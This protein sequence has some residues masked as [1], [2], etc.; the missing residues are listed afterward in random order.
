MPTDDDVQSQSSS[1]DRQSSRSSSE[2]SDDSY[3]F[4]RSRSYDSGFQTTPSSSFKESPTSSYFPKSSQF[5]YVQAKRAPTPYRPDRTSP[6]SSSPPRH[7]TWRTGSD[8]PDGYRQHAAHSYSHAPRLSQPRPRAS[9]IPKPPPPSIPV[10]VYTAGPSA[11]LHTPFCQAPI[12][13]HHPSHL[14]AHPRYA[15]RSCP[16]GYV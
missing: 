11:N 2:F 3:G 4:R 16:L 6:T 12:L 14:T 9:S 10:P 13:P 7:E 1:L 15:A 5:A 8:L